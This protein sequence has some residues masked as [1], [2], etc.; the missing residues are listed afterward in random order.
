MGDSNGGLY[1]RTVNNTPTRA[2]NGARTPEEL[3][4]LFEDGLVLRDP[5][6]LADLFESGAVLA[7]DDER[8]AHG[9][10]AIAQLALVTWAGDHTYI[11]EPKRVMQARDIALIVSGQ[12]INVVR[13]ATDGTWRYAIVRKSYGDN[14]IIEPTK[15]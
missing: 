8:T 3:E 1:I 13:R 15:E 2:R 14:L 5:Q 4:T 7:V 10:E 11:A 6:A 12:G 9:G